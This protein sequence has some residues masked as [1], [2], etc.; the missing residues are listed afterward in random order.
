VVEV[1]GPYR[2]PKRLQ[3]RLARQPGVEWLKAP[4]GA[5]EEARRVAAAPLHQGDLTAQLLDFGD[6][7]RV[8]RSSL[9]R[10]QQPER[11]IQRAGVA[12]RRGCREQ[13]LCPASGISCQHRRAF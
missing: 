5:K 7:Q 4:G 13:A 9:D 8:R 12:F 10:D 11:R 6:P 2:S 1:T 3:V